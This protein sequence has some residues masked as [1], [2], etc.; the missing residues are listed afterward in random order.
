MRTAIH[1][2]D[3]LSSALSLNRVYGTPPNAVLIANLVLNHVG[4]YVG[5][6]RYFLRVVT[7]LALDP[8]SGL[9]DL[10]GMEETTR[11]DEA[12]AELRAAAEDLIGIGIAICQELD[13]EVGRKVYQA[14]E[15]PSAPSRRDGGGPPHRLVTREALE[16]TLREFRRARD[17]SDEGR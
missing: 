10:P 5:F 8:A 2:V 17:D 11:L 14:V 12:K 6:I 16:E 1:A 3:D 13:G 4:R 9:W 15:G 7:V